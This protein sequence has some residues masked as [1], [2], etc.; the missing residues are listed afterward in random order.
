MTKP[1]TASEAKVLGCLRDRA[2]DDENCLPSGF[3]ASLTDLSL[4]QARRAIKSLQR[5]GYVEL[6]RGIFNSD[7]EIAGSGY[8]C[9][10]SGK[11]HLPQ[12]RGADV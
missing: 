9:T 11:Q 12:V 10:P 4:I 6:V 3:V 8:C 7:G 1:L 5:R 2:G